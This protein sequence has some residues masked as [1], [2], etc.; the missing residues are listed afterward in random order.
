MFDVLSFGDVVFLGSF[1]ADSFFV[2]CV[3]P[4]EDRIVICMMYQ[5]SS[6]AYALSWT[7][8]VQIL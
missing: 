7:C 4:G 1:G 5:N 6:S 8:T 2:I 3:L